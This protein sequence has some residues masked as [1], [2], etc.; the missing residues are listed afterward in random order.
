M[1]LKWSSSWLGCQQAW[2]C[3]S[4][5]EHNGD[6]RVSDTIRHQL[7]RG[8]L[9]SVRVI[10]SM[11]CE[12]EWCPWFLMV[13]MMVVVA[14]VLLDYECN[15]DALVH[16]GSIFQFAICVINWIALILDVWQGAEDDHPWG[17]TW[18]IQER[19]I[20]LDLILLVMT[21]GEDKDSH[22]VGILLSNP[23]AMM[24]EVKPWLE[25][26]LRREH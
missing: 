13:F 2:A 7:A 21:T 17:A 5:A 16:A 10:R 8:G 6:S 3:P 23:V 12:H 1:R 9:G 22:N 18:C 24:L 20:I 14:R 25:W 19:D 11:P 15:I 26:H 4:D